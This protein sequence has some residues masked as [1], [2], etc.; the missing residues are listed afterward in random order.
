MARANGGRT[1]FLP[2]SLP[3][4]SAQLLVFVRSASS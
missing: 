4:V 1:I 3:G 2:L